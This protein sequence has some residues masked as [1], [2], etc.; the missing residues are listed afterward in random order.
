MTLFWPPTAA[1]PKSTKKVE[2]TFKTH[3][4]DDHMTGIEK[5][6]HKIYLFISINQESGRDEW[7]FI[8]IL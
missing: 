8:G 7:R 2:L 6:H 5:I 4:P 1:Y 3:F